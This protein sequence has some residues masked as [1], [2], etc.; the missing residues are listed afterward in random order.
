MRAVVPITTPPLA[1]TEIGGPSLA[2]FRDAQDRLR[3]LTGELVTFLGPVQVTFPPGTRLD[4]QS[5]RPYDPTITPSSS[6]R[7]S[8]AVK[9]G[10]VS[11]LG[12]GQAQP[13]GWTPEADVMLHMPSAAAS[14]ASAAEFM[15][16]GKLWKVTGRHFEGIGDLTNRIHVFG[17]RA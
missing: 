16:R 8:A 6:A 13:L 12:D 9:A 11:S 14:A 1:D 7:A 3:A 4:P 10:V 17:K 15:L 2:G 5:G